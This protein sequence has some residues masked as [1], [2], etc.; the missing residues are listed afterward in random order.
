[1]AVQKR[2]ARLLAVTRGGHPKPLAFK[3]LCEQVADFS[4]VIDD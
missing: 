4:I 3:E 2:P 1:M